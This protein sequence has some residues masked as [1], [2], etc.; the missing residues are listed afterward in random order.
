MLWEETDRDSHLMIGSVVGRSEQAS[1]IGI[2]YKRSNLE[3]WGFFVFFFFFTTYFVLL[4][5]VKVLVS[6]YKLLIM[7]NYFIALFLLE[8]LL[9]R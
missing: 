2:I 8:M 9:F 4:G 5:K 1:V 3:F 7:R 6:F